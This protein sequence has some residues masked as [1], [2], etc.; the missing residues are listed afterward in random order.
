MVSAHG[1]AVEEL[2]LFDL[3]ESAAKEGGASSAVALDVVKMSFEGAETLSWKEL[4]SG[5]D[6]LHAITYSSGLHF[7][8]QFLSQILRP[9][10]KAA[11]EDIEAS[12]F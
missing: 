7:V 3:G 9:H 10:L 2:S 12:G 4:F 1:E 5:F 6:T 11:K 8:C